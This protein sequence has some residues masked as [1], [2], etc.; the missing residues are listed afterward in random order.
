MTHSMISS[1]APVSWLPASLRTENPYKCQ[2][3][4]L[5]EQ[6]LSSFCTEKLLEDGSSCSGMIPGPAYPKTILIMP[7]PLKGT[8]GRLGP[9]EPCKA[10]L[11]CAPAMLPVPQQRAEGRERGQS[12]RHGMIY[13][14]PEPR[15][16]TH[17]PRAIPLLRTPLLQS[18]PPGLVITLQILWGC[19]WWWQRG[20]SSAP[21]GDTQPV[22]YP[23]FGGHS[24]RT[25]FTCPSQSQH[26]HPSCLC[27]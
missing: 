10:R 4:L 23:G 22:S 8:G 26:L 7:H 5:W 17:M 16:T 6:A 25:E 11:R 21:S 9:A 15:W 13:M 18:L 24:P 19:R 20:Q 12:T 3:V 14:S 1:S 27:P 2:A